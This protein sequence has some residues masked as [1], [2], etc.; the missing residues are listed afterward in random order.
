MTNE[1]ANET[2]RSLSAKLAEFRR[3]LNPD[4]TAL[5][6][7]VLGAAYE[8]D[9]A[10]YDGIGPRGPLRPGGPLGHTGVGPVFPVPASAVLGESDEE[11][12]ARFSRT[13]STVSDAIRNP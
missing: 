7:A 13:G 4:E 8:S 10:G 11:I 3:T 6:N 2:V 9:V 1:T 12:L 5:L